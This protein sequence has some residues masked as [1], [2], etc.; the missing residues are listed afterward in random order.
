[1]E[2]FFQPSVKRINSSILLYQFFELPQKL[3]NHNTSILQYQFFEHKQK[4]T[5][6]NSSV[7]LYQLFGLTQKVIILILR[8]GM[9]A[10]KPT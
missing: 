10:G 9:N 3:I 8:F 2:L 1:M 4:L 5:N 6:H 7:L